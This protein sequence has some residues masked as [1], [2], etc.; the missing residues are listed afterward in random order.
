MMSVLL[1]QR[2]TFVGCSVVI[3]FGEDTKQ[4]FNVGMH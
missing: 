4:L 3:N 2:D 1:G